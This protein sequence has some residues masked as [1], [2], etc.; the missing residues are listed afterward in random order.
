MAETVSDNFEFESGKPKQS[1]LKDNDTYSAIQV[2]GS[3]FKNSENYLNYANN[4]GRIPLGMF[5]FEEKNTS[6]NSIEI[7]SDNIIFDRLPKE[8]L[9]NNGNCENVSEFY[10]ETETG[11]FTKCLKPDG[12]W[13]HLNTQGVFTQTIKDDTDNNGEVYWPFDSIANEIDDDGETPSSVQNRF[14]LKQ[15]FYQDTAPSFDNQGYI[16][17]GGYYPYIPIGKN[18]EDL[19]KYYGI[20][21]GGYFSS[22]V[23]NN[24]SWFWYLAD[25]PWSPLPTIATWI[26]D[27][28]AYS[29]NRCLIF[30]SPEQWTIPELVAIGEGVDSGTNSLPMPEFMDVLKSPGLVAGTTY[31]VDISN[32]QYRLL[33]Q[34]QRI[35]P[36]LLS[37]SSDLSLK[38]KF[39][40]KTIQRSQDLD[41]E[42]FPEVEAGI[43]KMVGYSLDQGG[44]APEPLEILLGQSGS[45]KAYTN[46]EGG[47][48]SKKYYN[49]N[50]F[51]EKKASDF[52]GLFNF[53]NTE[54][55]VWEQMEFY[56]TVP[57]PSSDSRVN[58]LTFIIQSGKNFYGT[59]LMDD[60][61]IFES[62]DF[63]PDVDVR[64]KISVGV[65]GKG[66]LT[67]YYDKDLQPQE[68]KDT[69]A[70]LEAQFYFNPRYKTDKIFDVER[71]PIYQD[72]KKGLFYVHDIDWGDGSP[73]E[74]VSEP[75]QID[76]EKVILHNYERSGIFKVTGNMLRLKGDSDGNPLGLVH[77]TT[78]SLYININEGDDDDFNFFNIDGFS[79]IPYK[80]TTPVIGGISEQSSYYKT[81]K[82]QLGFLDNG[83]YSKIEYPDRYSKIKAQ[84][85]LLKMNDLY[86]NVD[87]LGELNAYFNSYTQ[88]DYTPGENNADILEATSINNLNL[89]TEKWMINYDSFTIGNTP[90][91]PFPGYLTVKFR[92][93][94]VTPE[95]YGQLSDLTDLLEVD[96]EYVQDYQYI[97][98]N[99][100]QQWGFFHITDT[101]LKVKTIRVYDGSINSIGNLGTDTLGISPLKISDNLV[102]DSSNGTNARTMYRRD[103]NDGHSYLYYAAQQ[104][105][106]DQEDWILD[107]TYEIEIEGQ[108]DYLGIYFCRYPVSTSAAKGDAPDGNHVVDI[109][110]FN[111]F[112]INNMESAFGGA[113]VLEV[114]FR[115]LG[116]STLAWPFY[117]GDFIPYPASTDNP[118]MA[119]TDWA[120]LSRWDIAIYLW[121]IKQ[122][123]E[124]YPDEYL[125]T[126]HQEILDYILI[127]YEGTM[128]NSNNL[129]EWIDSDQ[130]LGGSIMPILKNS[131]ESNDIWSNFNESQE[132][133]PPLPEGESL[134]ELIF[135]GIKPLAGELG[136]SI[137]DCDVTNIKYY[138]KSKSIWELFGFEE[139]DFNKVGN[140]NDERYWKNIIPKGYS[141]FNRDGITGDWLETNRGVD[142]SRTTERQ[143][144]VS[145]PNYGIEV[146]TGNSQL[147]Q[148]VER[149]IPSSDPY[150]VEI[151][152]A[153]RIVTNST[154]LDVLEE[155]TFEK[156]FDITSGFFDHYSDLGDDDYYV[157]SFLWDIPNDEPTIVT[158]DDYVI[159]VRKISDVGEFATVGYIYNSW[160]DPDGNPDTDLTYD[161]TFSI[162][163]DYVEDDDSSDEAD[164]SDTDDNNDS[165]SDDNDNDN[166]EDD[167]TT[168][169]PP[170]DPDGGDEN[171]N[172]DIDINYGFSIDTYS[173]QDWLNGYYYPVL[174]KYGADGK[175]IEGDFPNNNIPFSLEGSITDQ[176]ESDKNLL[177]NITTN[178]LE[179]NTFDDLSGNGNIALAISDYKL[180]LTEKLTFEKTKNFKKLK[181]KNKNGAF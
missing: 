21:P 124:Y 108:Q 98:S 44:G 69:I 71:T 64:K 155:V 31:H 137:G 133:P 41:Q 22:V 65:Y 50:T 102:Y 25:D 175:F 114:I 141:I 135:K 126:T 101:N 74:F 13:V 149:N 157:Y 12:G 66:E 30:K 168:P 89:F 161:G 53:S 158:G 8:N 79:T 70:P 45:I 140:P 92:I 57:A 109:R 166:G 85:T 142:G 78:F 55:D 56:V 121:F 40:M 94:E 143:I 33:N 120:E 151:F 134:T 29:Y 111:N 160:T 48:N 107:G 180:K 146:S 100:Y 38:V 106:Q 68:Y 61:E 6:D 19:K 10:Y 123:Q 67:E 5:F 169:P 119:Y 176:N 162:L 72:F 103:P 171:S 16:N 18:N 62:H 95:G 117:L 24:D 93:N 153:K 159:G 130:N 127:S 4:D 122:Y 173:E 75:E 136:K 58:I 39:K 115:D 99:F 73:K 37:P 51:N 11:I 178:K 84:S 131:Y 167:D 156:I 150:P 129:D 26:Q 88:Q 46:A 128:E 125:N 164:D 77:S 172:L 138:S 59:V 163:S 81:I 105:S 49:G 179:T 90:D 3:E 144:W 132:W 87:E 28:G 177:I 118:I 145:E 9:I 36:S 139:Y 152:L 154:D 97:S 43:I 170:S 54:E 110:N 83:G 113:S 35:N 7:N 76:E 86:D 82:R 14:D 112:D 42:T 32:N 27:N 15:Y 147:I 91:N 47:F 181:T 148:W 2:T 174:P 1:L 17:Y 165:V 52:G 20:G 34:A 116:S 104:L 63:Y 96:T 23:N 60:F 80:N